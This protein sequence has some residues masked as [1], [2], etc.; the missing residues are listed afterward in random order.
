MIKYSFILGNFILICA[1]FGPD[2]SLILIQIQLTKF[3]S[4]NISSHIFFKFV[5][6]LS[7]IDIN[8]TPSSV[9]KFLASCSVFPTRLG[10]ST[11]TI[12][13]PLL[14][15]KFTV[16]PLLTVSPQVTQKFY[17]TF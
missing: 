14:T 15:T 10:T 13:L 12:P 4:P 1:I 8:I 3:S 5:T 6:S 17:R 16:L 11:F 7:S 2:K 9:N